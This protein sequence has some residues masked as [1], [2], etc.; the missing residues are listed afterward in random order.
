MLITFLV[1]G[2]NIFKR[3]WNNG[4]ASIRLVPGCSMHHHPPFAAIIKIRMNA[5]AASKF[6]SYTDLLPFRPSGDAQDLWVLPRD[7]CAEDGC[8]LLVSRHGCNT[9]VR[10]LNT[11]GMYN[12]MHVTVG[13][14]SSSDK[15]HEDPTATH[16]GSHVTTSILHIGCKV[17]GICE[18]FIC[19]KIHV[20]WVQNDVERNC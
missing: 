19:Q 6:P 14:T 8:F 5:R 18:P 9:T 15:G 11:L 3:Y 16:R 17:K 10:H 13:K 1:T 12:G 2:G 4:W 7:L 20:G